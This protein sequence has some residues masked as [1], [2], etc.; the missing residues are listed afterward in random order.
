[1]VHEVVE[2]G[3][4][5]RLELSVESRLSEDEVLLQ[6]LHILL[7]LTV[8]DGSRRSRRRTSKSSSVRVVG[9]GARCL[10]FNRQE[11]CCRGVDT[12]HF[13]ARSWTTAVDVVGP[14]SKSTS[15]RFPIEKV[16]ILLPHKEVRVVHRVHC[17]VSGI[18]VIYCQ[19]RLIR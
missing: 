10:K 11:E 16:Q 1:A 5:V 7:E 9:Q 18:V 19:S 2:V 17:R 8:Q 15:V 3:G 12:R 4:L 6:L 13:R 14:E